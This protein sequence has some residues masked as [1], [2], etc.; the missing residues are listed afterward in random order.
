MTRQ[1]GDAGRHPAGRSDSMDASDTP[2]TNSIAALRRDYMS[3]G[4]TE[5]E[6]DA[7]PVR[8]FAVWFDA[9]LAAH[10]LEPNAM[11]LATATPDGRPSARMVLLKGFDQRGFVWYT[12][13]ESHKGG[14]LAANPYAALVFFWVELARQVRIEGPVTR[15]APE[16][17]DAYFQSR[18]RGSQ[19]GAAASRQS[20]VLPSREPLEQRAAE[21]EA[22]Y[23]GQVV[24]RPPYW[25]GYRLSAT[26]IEFWQGR[27]SRLHDRLRYH[28]LE[29]GAWLLERLSP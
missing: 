21:L 11:A 18:P 4:L 3:Q 8:Q 25:G 12:N 16:E 2:G 17:S 28:R 1:E 19:V 24:P 6:V 20:R 15:V 7:D 27:P 14:E 29:D 22:E 26:M 23:A 5:G 10:L 9:A 13:Y